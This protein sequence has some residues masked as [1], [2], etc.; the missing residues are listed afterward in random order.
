MGEIIDGNAALEADSHSAEWTAGLA[1][2]GAPKTGFT[3]DQDGGGHSGSLRDTHCFSVYEKVDRFTR[4]LH[5]SSL[6]SMA[7][8]ELR[9]HDA[10]RGRREVWPCPERL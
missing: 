3:R 6:A 7:R 8:E 10:A 4:G 9:I 1:G 2:H 5:T